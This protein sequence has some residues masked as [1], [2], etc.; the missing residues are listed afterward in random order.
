MC[1]EAQLPRKWWDVY[2]P[3]GGS[4]YIPYFSLLMRADFA[5]PTKL[6]LS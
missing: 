5:L 1:G 6:P 2:L 3:M 4:Q